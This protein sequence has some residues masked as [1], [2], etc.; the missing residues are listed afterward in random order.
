MGRGTRADEDGAGVQAGAAGT[1]VGR[2]M[3]GLTALGLLYQLLYGR[4]AG[5]PRTIAPDGPTIVEQSPPED[6]KD[7]P[8]ANL[9]EPGEATLSEDRRRYILDEDGE[10]GG[11]HGPGRSTPGKSEFPSD[12]S[13]EKVTDA[14]KDV[15][16]DP[17]SVRTP[18]DRGRTSI[19][20]TRD[21]IGIRVI[22]GADGKTI[23]AAYPTNVP[24]NPRRW[25][26]LTTRGLKLTS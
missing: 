9:A 18:A 25:P 15:A 5:P 3:L 14:I 17:A 12:W 19:E 21:G 24:R 10:G 6:K 4:N 13:D 8:P 2:S 16:N 1:D 7:A 26:C 23:V 22:I 11:G 20:G